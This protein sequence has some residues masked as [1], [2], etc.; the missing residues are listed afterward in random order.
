VQ[1]EDKDGISIEISLS[2]KAS[3]VVSRL[4]GGFSDIGNVLRSRV[5]AQNSTSALKPQ[6]SQD[7]IPTV[8]II[9][10]FN[11]NIDRT[12]V[13]D[14]LYGTL[15]HDNTREAK[16][17]RFRK[18]DGRWSL[19]VPSD[20]NAVFVLRFEPISVKM[21]TV[22]AYLCPNPKYVFESSM[23]SIPNLSWRRLNAS[24][25]DVEESG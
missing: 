11:S 8:L 17:P 9:N 23:F 7:N 18:N 19:S 21:D 20:L 4:Y 1:Y 2:P 13:E 16:T 5:G 6:V 3:R 12:V 24:S 14:A 25:V 10:D 15:V 22:D